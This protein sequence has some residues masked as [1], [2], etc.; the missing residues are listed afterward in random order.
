MRDFAQTF[1][2]MKSVAVFVRYWEYMPI[3]TD[4]IATLLLFFTVKAFFA[5]ALGMR[6]HLA[7]R[8]RYRLGSRN[9]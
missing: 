3:F 9:C 4:K 5:C 2:D 8:V 1:L 7:V 6:Y